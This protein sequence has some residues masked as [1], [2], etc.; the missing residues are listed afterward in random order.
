MFQDGIGKGEMID[1][2]YDGSAAALLAS[3]LK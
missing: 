1:A 3:K 2:I